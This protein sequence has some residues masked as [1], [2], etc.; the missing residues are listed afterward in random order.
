MSVKEIS[1]YFVSKTNFIDNQELHISSQ[2]EYPLYSF[3]CQKRR[4][5]FQSSVMHL[6]PEK[7]EVLIFQLNRMD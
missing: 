5:Y 4:K 7:R 1:V 3:P 6:G 2:M